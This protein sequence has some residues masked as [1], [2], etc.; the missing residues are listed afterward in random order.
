M[1]SR[2]GRLGRSHENTIL[3]PREDDDLRPGDNIPPSG[4]EPEILRVRNFSTKS[5]NLVNRG[6]SIKVRNRGGGGHVVQENGG[7]CK[8]GVRG[9]VTAGGTTNQQQA[10]FS[11]NNS[12]GGLYSSSVNVFNG[13]GG[14]SAGNNEAYLDEAQVESVILGLSECFFPF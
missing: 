11:R 4:T 5:G 3:S 1:P 2:R 7:S 9:L 12:Q 13:G 6:D 10:P 8:G 14:V